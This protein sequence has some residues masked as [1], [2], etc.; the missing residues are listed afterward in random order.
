MR[1]GTLGVMAEGSISG[2]H[3]VK[4]AC[5]RVCATD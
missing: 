4:T 5:R 3:A 1:S 2:E